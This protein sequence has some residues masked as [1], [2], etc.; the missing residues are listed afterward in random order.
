MK[1][2]TK[3]GII[4]CLLAIMLVSPLVLAEENQTSE[5][6]VNLFWEK[7]K[8]MLTFNQEKKA[9][10]ELN[11]ADAMLSKAE[12]MAEKG[13]MEAMESAQ[14]EFEKLTAK[15]EIRIEKMADL[16]GKNEQIEKNVGKIAEFENTISNQE[17][18]IVRLNNILLDSNLSNEK[19]ERISLMIAK[20]GNKTEKIR[21]IL[22]QKEEKMQL[23][24]MAKNN[25]TEEEAEEELEKMRENQGYAN[26]TQKTALKRITQTER[27]IEKAELLLD[28]WSSE[29]CKTSNNNSDNKCINSRTEGLNQSIN[30]AK[31]K[32]A[33]AKVAYEMGNY[34]E[35]ISLLKNAIGL[36]E[37]LTETKSVGNGRRIEWNETEDNDDKTKIPETARNGR[38]N[39]EIESD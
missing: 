32:L 38:E 19:K 25:M 15:A 12:K 30:N 1:Q 16:N 5:K 14:K 17:D 4:S 9:Q 13:N 35:V 2:M 33:L 26:F 37:I 20:T 36:G 28:G 29:K 22:S 39:D 3:I 21:E 34:Q 18:K 23:K 24:V 11:L 7:L 6:D 31:E 8:I 27:A 10:M